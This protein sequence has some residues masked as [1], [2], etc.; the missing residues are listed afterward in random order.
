MDPQQLATLYARYG[1]YVQRRCAALLG[2]A[3][4]ADDALQEVFLRVQKYGRPE[5]TGSDLG[6]LYTIATRV[7]F[8]LRAKRR[9]VT[10]DPSEL[11]AL[12]GRTTDASPDVRAV[13][14]LA[15]RNMD[16]RTAELGVMHHLDG[17]TQEEMAE[18]TGISRKTIGKKL[19]VFEALVREVFTR[20]NL[21]GAPR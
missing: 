4:E 17:Y 2:S 14:G 6:W 20:T 21:K 9:E 7:C 18:R 16:E 3:T 11:P 8:D 12:D 19:A 13:V 10:V 15:L 5:A 1:Y